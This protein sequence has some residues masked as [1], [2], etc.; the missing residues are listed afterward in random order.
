L[1][2]FV[3][4]RYLFQPQVDL[5]PS[6][7]EKIMNLA[8]GAEYTPD[9]LIEAGE[10]IF[11]TERLFLT[12]AGFSRKDDTLPKRM[13]EEPLTEGGGKGNVCELDQMLPEYYNLRGWDQNGIP[14]DEKLKQLGIG[15]S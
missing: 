5:V 7:L 12:K 3:S 10:R 6:R 11:N 1:C 4:I 2:V 9:S 13:L 15:R 8:T 14:T